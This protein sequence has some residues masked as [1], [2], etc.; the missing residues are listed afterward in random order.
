MD[1]SFY[2]LRLC[3]SDLIL[4]DDLGGDGRDRDWVG[5]ARALLHRRR[6]AG[7]ARLALVSKPE[8]DLWLRVFSPEGEGG[9]CADAALC[10]ARYLLDR[11]RRAS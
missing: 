1:L 5:L 3:D 10:A 4:F 8:R 2:K 7:A 6:G 11:S 9:P